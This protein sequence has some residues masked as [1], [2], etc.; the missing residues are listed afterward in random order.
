MNNPLHQSIIAIKGVGPA[1]AG[2]LAKLGVHTVLDALF[3][4]PRRVQEWLPASSFDTL[5]PG[6]MTVVV[7]QLQKITTLRTRKRGM[8]ITTA[9]ITDEKGGTLNL[10]WFRQPYVEKQLEEGGWYRFM[11]RVDRGAQGITMIAP[12]YTPH[13]PGAPV[14]GY[15]DT[16]YPLTAGLKPLAVSSLMKQV[17]PHGHTYREWADA[18]WLR[19]QGFPRFPDIFQ[20]LHDPHSVQEWGA[21]CRRL[22][23]D[24][25]VWLRYML[26]VR[27]QVLTTAPAHAIPF[28][29]GRAR[30]YVASLPFPLTQGQKT[31]IWEALTDMQKSSPMHRILVGEVGSGKTAVACMLFHHVLTHGGQC[32]LMAPTELLA[33][34]HAHTCAHLLPGHTIVLV[35]GNNRVRVEGE[36]TTEMS[37]DELSDVMARTSV[38]FIGTHALTGEHMKFQHVRLVVV[39]EQHR[40]G[41]DKRTALGRYRDSMGRLPHFLMMTATPIPRSVG[42]ILFGDMDMSVLSEVPRGRMPVESIVCEERTTG[43]RELWKSVGGTVESGRQVFI[44]C[45][46]I[47]AEDDELWSVEDMVAYT[48]KK[49]PHARVGVLHGELSSMEQGRVSDRMVSGDIDI[50]IATTIVEVGVNVPNATIMVICNAEYFG[51]ATLHQLRGRIGRGVHPGIC[52]LLT[53][54]DADDV[55][56]ERVSLMVKNKDGFSL[57]QEDMRLRGFG[58]L[59]GDAQSGGFVFKWARFADSAILDLA[60]VYAQSMQI[61]PAL[62]LPEHVAHIMRDEESSQ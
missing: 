16:L 55:A 27:S 39:D 9:R 25:L 3:F 50:I 22:A 11:G 45:P 20:L 48:K 29:E 31:A 7:G 14:A 15:I 41:V 60:R 36:T 37:A 47:H 28:D 54:K 12:R 43:E 32:V 40:F 46:R 49:V 34:Q 4:V 23:F 56:H 8:V 24:E 17:I 19:A 2:K 44:V 35:A 30:E 1:T 10:A 53:G 57:A 26:R 61:D 59:M 51:L 58:A 42:H 52:Y 21:A 38:L 13:E 5:M 18:H 33:R 62:P 6:T